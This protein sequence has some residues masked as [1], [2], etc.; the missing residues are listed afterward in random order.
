[1]KLDELKKELAEK[2]TM[3]ERTQTFFHQL[4][5]QIIMLKEMIKKEET[6]KV[7]EIKK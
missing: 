7:E 3:K 6:I 1:M 4:T 2:E 5:G